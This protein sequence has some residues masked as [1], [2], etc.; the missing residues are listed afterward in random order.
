MGYSHEALPGVSTSSRSHCFL[1]VF[2]LNLSFLEFIREDM[3]S[4]TELNATAG[5][6]NV[7]SDYIGGLELGGGFKE[8]FASGSLR[9]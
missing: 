9:L 8:K 1:F 5:T 7:D 4:V 6:E 3:T 2:F